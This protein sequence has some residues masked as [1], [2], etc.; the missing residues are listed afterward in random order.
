MEEDAR[1]RKH[2]VKWILRAASA[3]FAGMREPALWSLLLCY[4]VASFA[5]SALCGGSRYPPL[6]ARI[7][8]TRLAMPVWF[9]AGPEPVSAA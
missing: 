3:T 1:K 4:A 8:C 2:S 5:Y 7:R 9:R 6:A